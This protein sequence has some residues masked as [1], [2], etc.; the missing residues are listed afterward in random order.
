MCCVVRRDQFGGVAGF[1]PPEKKL[2]RVFVTDFTAPGGD[3]PELSAYDGGRPG[4]L[5]GEVTLPALPNPLLLPPALPGFGAAVVAGGDAAAEL[6]LAERFM[7]IAAARAD[8]AFAAGAA[9]AAGAELRRDVKK[10]GSSTSRRCTGAAAAT[11][12]AS[13]TE[14]LVLTNG[15]AL[16]ALSDGW[17]TR[18]PDADA[19]FDALVLGR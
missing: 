7:L 15:A 10:S 5:E 14:V 3:C 18:P 17:R 19:L 11:A 2:K 16:D 4:P 1:G 12:A 6:R 9:A 13:G 8:G